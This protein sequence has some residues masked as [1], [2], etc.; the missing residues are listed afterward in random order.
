M[1]WLNEMMYVSQLPQCPTCFSWDKQWIADSFS[2]EQTSTYMHTVYV[3]ASTVPAYPPALFASFWQCP[4]H[5]YTCTPLFIYNLFYFLFLPE[6]T[7]F[8]DPKNDLNS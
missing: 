1:G 8:A 6:N 3:S 4:F 7:L 5:F 2:V